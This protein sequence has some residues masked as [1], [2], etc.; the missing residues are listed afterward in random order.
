[1]NDKENLP[2]KKL[3]P[4]PKTGDDKIVIIKSTGY[5]GRVVVGGEGGGGGWCGKERGRTGGEKEGRKGRP[6]FDKNERKY[7]K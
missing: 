5:Y 3:K 7:K 4:I 1:M 2:L 6:N